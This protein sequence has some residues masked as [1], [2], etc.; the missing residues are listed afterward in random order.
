MS[1]ESPEEA[2]SAFYRAFEQ[3][4][5][6]AMMKVWADDDG[7][8]C[9]HP[10]GPRLVGRRT[11]GEGWRHI[12]A[13]SGAMRFEL[14]D[15]V[16][17]LIGDVAVRCLLEHIRFGPGLAQHGVVIATNV[18]RRTAAGWR[19]IAHHASP[20]PAPEARRAPAAPAT[21]H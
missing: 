13:G 16:Q 8:V 20:G 18:Y 12:F 21:V 2:E 19:M 10:M 7:I 14:G 3:C 9:I 5:L 17:N 1:F 6:D 4:S 15:V 11:V